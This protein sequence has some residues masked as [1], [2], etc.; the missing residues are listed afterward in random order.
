MTI[1][2][3]SPSGR[4]D[5]EPLVWRDI[6]PVPPQG[7]E[8]TRH[9]D[10][11][12]VTVRLSGHSL[13]TPADARVHV[14]SALRAWGVPVDVTQDLRAITSELTTNSVTHT[15]SAHLDVSALLTEKEASVVV[16]DR[17][18]YRPLAP[19]Q[20]DPDDEHGRGLAL[21]RAL[22]SRWEARPYGEGTAVWA[23]IA[24]P[25]HT[26]PHPCEVETDAARTHR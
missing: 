10:Q 13:H 2:P 18:P 1:H 3:S 12:S 22:A 24:L 23:A 16:I 25:E 8:T 20:A 11:R 17:G 9:G 6:R 5:V 14:V 4:S 26:R 7:R 15:R 19:H 21:V